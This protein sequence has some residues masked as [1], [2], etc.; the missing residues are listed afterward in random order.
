MLRPIILTACLIA[1]SSHSAALAG[2]P[3]SCSGHNRRPANPNG[4]VLPGTTV[5]AVTAP[6]AAPPTPGPDGRPA[7]VPAQGTV[8]PSISGPSVPAPARKGK[9]KKV[10][11]LAP[12]QYPSCL[13]VLG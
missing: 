11:A 7:R 9:A 4:S 8:V 5:A 3:K 10:S 1:L 2:K 12:S 6:I 13:E